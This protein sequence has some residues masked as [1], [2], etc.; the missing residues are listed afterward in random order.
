MLKLS[1]LELI[2]RGI[3]EDLVFF[4]A[5]Y[6]FTKIK[7]EKKR[8]LISVI[9]QSII[10]YLIR[11]LPIQNGADSILNL[12]LLILLSVYVNK[13]EIIQAIKAGII[14]ML[15]EFISEGINVFFIQFILRKDLNYIFRDPMLKIIYSSPSLLIFACFVIIYYLILWKRKELKNI[16]YGKVDE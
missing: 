14:I 3:P 9:I 11:F 1:F 8:Y 10:V 4:L 16:S 13:I 7:V 12:T 2:I 15:C 5:V 6:T